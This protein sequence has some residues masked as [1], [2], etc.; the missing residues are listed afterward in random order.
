MECPEC[1]HGD[2]YKLR[3]EPKYVCS[4]CAAWF[5]PCSG[6]DGKG[7][8]DCPVCEGDGLEYWLPTHEETGSEAR[9]L[10]GGE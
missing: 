8:N 5:V 9:K 10:D 6:C 4:E 3:N 2:L 7:Y 1:L